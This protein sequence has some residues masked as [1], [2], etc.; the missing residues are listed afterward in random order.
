MAAQG[1]PVSIAGVAQAYEDFLDML[2]VDR[3]DAELPRPS[4]VQVHATNIIM[5]SGEDRTALANAL[6]SAVAER[7]ALSPT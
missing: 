3:A 6:L 1:L 2:I 7:Q 5:K 4:G